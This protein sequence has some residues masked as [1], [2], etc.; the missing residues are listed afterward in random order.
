V[1]KDAIL[2]LPADPIRDMLHDI[3]DYVVARVS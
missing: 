2:T 3:A 1:A